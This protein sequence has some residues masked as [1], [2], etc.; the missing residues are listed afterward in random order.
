MTDIYILANSLTSGGSEKQLITLVKF[1]DVKKVVLLENDIF[2]D[3]DFKDKLVLLSN[4]KEYSN[5]I[6]KCLDFV[7]SLV[8]LIRVINRNSIVISF[9][10]RGNIANVLLKKIKNSKVILT[11]GT[12]LS[13]AMNGK[14]GSVKKRIIS[15]L[16]KRGDLIIVNSKGIE[17]DLKKSFGIAANKIRTVYNPIEIEEIKRQG[18]IPIE[19]EFLEIF[20]NP[21]ILTMGR[22]TEAKGQ[23]HLIRIFWKVKE[24]IRDAKLIIISD[25]ELKSYL[26]E[27]AKGLGLKVYSKNDKMEITRN[28]DVY[29]LGY[30]QEPFKYVARSKLFVFTSLWEGLPNALIEAMACGTPVISSDCRSGPREL[31]APKTRIEYETKDVEFAKYGILMPVCC[32]KMNLNNNVLS[33]EEKIWADVLVNLIEDHSLLHKCVRLGKE[34]IKDFS[35]ESI[36]K[37][38][39]NILDD[40]NPNFEGVT[41][42]KNKI[43]TS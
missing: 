3:V 8:K 43:L 38:W 18:E 21:V 10:V 35:A 17:S 30:T 23:W 25:G 4:H 33:K 5:P 13:R 12:Q 41:K 37:S 32:G 24:A 22:L 19:N 39:Q 6:L 11:E 26:M 31:L 16:Y 42:I 28:Y 27:V 9:L 2:Y 20:K 15:C 1:L 14:L 34:R 40:L 29:F 7:L 36:C